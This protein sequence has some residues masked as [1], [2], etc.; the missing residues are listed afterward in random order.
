MLKLDDDKTEYIIIGTD[1]SLKTVNTESIKVGNLEI[2]PVKSVRNIGA[3][4]NI[5]SIVF[6]IRIRV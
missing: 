2:I 1:N 3:K 4:F 5:T 6:R